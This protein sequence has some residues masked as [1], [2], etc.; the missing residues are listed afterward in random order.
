MNRMPPKSE[1]SA[2]WTRA[3]ILD[4]FA[5]PFNDLMTRAQEVLR[6]NFPA[7]EVQ[8]SS[9]LSVKTGGCGEDCGYCA[10][11]KK[12]ETELE[13]SGGLMS[14]ADVLAAARKAKEAGAGR[15]CMSAAWRQLRDKEVGAVAEL[16]ENVKALGL[17]TCLTLGMLK[18]DQ[19]QR[20]KDAG[21][22]QPQYRH[23][24]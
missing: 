12:Y 3:A 4:L 13:A 2:A 1:T 10:Q 7:N 19:A 8:L 24:T 22:L 16:V 20:L 21:L 14:L 18:P 5:Q 11:S 17:E 9:L 23:V 15:F 6:A